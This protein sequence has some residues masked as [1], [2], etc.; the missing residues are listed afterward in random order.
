M[1]AFTLGRTVVSDYMAYVSSFLTILDPKIQAFVDEK[2]SNKVL[3]PDPLLQLSP[4]YESAETVAELATRGVLHPGCGALFRFGQ[5]TLRLHQHQ[6]TAIDIAATGNHYIVTTGTGSGKSLTYLIPIINHVL[7]HHPEQANVRAIIVYPMNALINS[8]LEALQRFTQNLTD[9]PVRCARY[10]GQESDTEKATIRENPPHILLTN[11][12]MLELMLTRPEERIFV[13]KGQSAIQ[14]I[15]LDEL[16]TYRGRQGAD[17]ALLMRRLRERCGNPHLQCIGTSATMASG[18]SRTERSAA[19]AN[20]AS[21]IFGVT[22]APEHVIDE[23]LRWSVSQ[24]RTPSLTELREA[25]ETPLPNTL[26]WGEMAQNPLVAWIETT[27]GLH[28]DDDGRLRRRE[29][30]TLWRGAEQLAAITSIDAKECSRKLR[31]LFQ[32]GSQQR[33]YGEHGLAFKLHQFISQGGSVYATIAPSE[34]RYLT[35]QGQHY[36]PMEATSQ[37][38]SDGSALLFPLVFCRVCGQEH[39]HCTLDESNYRVIPR[40]PLDRDEDAQAGYLLTDPEGFWPDDHLDLLPET[41]FNERKSGRKLKPS[42]IAFQPRKLFV[43]TDGTAFTAPSDDSLRCWFIP[44]P[45]LTCLRCGEVYTRRQSDFSKLAR[46]SNEGRSTATTLLTLSA[47]TQMRADAAVHDNARKLL[48]FTDNRQDASLQA[49]HFNDFVS[50]ALLRAA[51]YRAVAKDPDGLNH[52]VIAQRT[53]EELNLPETDYAREVI[54]GPRARQN[55]AALHDLIEYRIYEDLRRGWRLMQPNLEQ[56]GLL[57]IDY[58]SLKEVC[59]NDQLWSSYPLL[60]TTPPETRFTITRTVLD[61]MRRELAIDAECLRS[62][63]QEALIRKVQSAL[64]DPW[65]FD[66]NEQLRQAYRFVLPGVP[67]GDREQRSLG[68]NTSLGRYLRA[69]QTWLTRTDPL[70]VDEYAKM[71]AALIETLRKTGYLVEVD[72]TSGQ[73]VQLRADVLIWRLGDNTVL[74]DPIRT[75]RMNLSYEPT[76]KPN[77]FFAEFYKHTATSLVK[78]EGREHTGQVPQ[79]EREDREQRFRE[80]EL[81]ALF[82]SPTMEL[83][84]DIADLNVVHLRNVPPTPANYAQRSGRAGRS[85]QAAFVATY[86]SVGSGHDQYFYRRPERM[87]SGVVVPPRFDL[88]NPDLIRAHV[89]AVWLAYTGLPLK[90]SMIDLLDTADPAHNYPLRD[91]IATSLRLNDMLRQQCLT[92]CRA[93][94]STVEGEHE[95]YNDEWLAPIIHE[96]ATNFDRACDRWRDLYAAAEEQLQQARRE[97]DER[98]TRGSNTPDARHARQRERESLRQKDLLC[99]TSTG[100]QDESDF[101]PY[102]YFASEGFLPGYNFPRLPIRAFLSTSIEEGV[103]LARPRF[104]ALSEFGPRNII[105][106]EG[107]KYRIIRTIAPSGSIESRLV[108]A[109]LCHNCGFFHDGTNVTTISHCERCNVLFDADNSLTTN[110]LFEMTTMATQRIERITS[111]EEERTRQGYYIT[112]HYR[113]DTTA[114]GT[115]LVHAHVQDRHND[116]LLHLTFAAAATLW[117]INHRWRRSTTDGFTLDVRRGFWDKRPGD[118][119]DREMEAKEEQRLSGVRVMVRDTRNILLIRTAHPVEEGVLAS[120]Q[121]ALQR[122][123]EAVFQVEEQEIASERIGADTHRQILF[124]EASEGGAGVLARLANEPDALVKVAQTAQEICHL[125]TETSD[126][127]KDCAKAC[128]RCLLSYANQPDHALLDRFAVRDIVDELVQSIT[129]GEQPTIDETA[130]QALSET[131]GGCGRVV[132]HLQVT[133]RRM[134]TA[135]FP[136]LVDVAIQPDLFYETPTGCICVFCDETPP[137]DDVVFLREDLID[138]GYRIIVLQA[139]DD[140]ETQL[141]RYPDVFGDITPTP[142]RNM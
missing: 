57:L 44:A 46:L 20:V 98:Y 81:Q 77:P 122:G 124:W 131:T 28:K 62:D 96:A 91:E 87:V 33:M 19:V 24:P 127:G 114:G 2:L 61:Y 41:W 23:T 89:Q 53:V 67:S 113:F 101:Y 106:H 8:Q 21:K 30:I 27:F 65:A 29:P 73:A 139:A 94:L 74:R 64:K 40:L 75:R 120:L 55:R 118:E 109:K 37:S 26:S 15:V 104:L 85:G 137:T 34:Q 126:E 38:N 4:A 13:E 16:H 51:L 128:Y 10:T 68:P 50:T 31:E 17:V 60:Q 82:C 18:T 25:M 78:T 71:M 14:F 54:V 70:S 84:I 115:R 49:G 59:D 47:I 12:V 130:I 95:R 39:Y 121:Y 69:R 134:P 136:N 22:V 35:L 132:A 5:H 32:K 80:G 90:R 129:V 125:T 3:W 103:F 1:D 138:L 52:E 86:C 6:R 100:R 108:T 116:P 66:D 56:C 76:I 135:V 97:I 93:I 58:D 45:F 110:R 105:Y 92:T 11:Y 107:R 88:D 99:N 102:R 7:N 141:A 140:L 42:H 123:I 112:T 63:R 72:G 48:S 117:R 111:E 9:C 119:A 36:A 43:R 142:D 79:R 133:G 83:G